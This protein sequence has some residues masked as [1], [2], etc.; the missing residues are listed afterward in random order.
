MSSQASELACRLAYNA[1]AVCRQYL[2]NGHR[3]GHYWIVGDVANTPGRSLYVR[4]SGPLSGKGARG[5]WT[6]AATGQR[7]DLLDLI[8]LS[9]GFDHLSKVIAEA[10]RFLGLPQPTP[11]RP[12]EPER[13]T[14]KAARRLLVMSRPLAGTLAETYLR[15]RGIAVTPD[16]WPLRFHPRCFCRTTDAPSSASHYEV[17]PALLAAVTS[18][19]GKVTGALRTFLDPSGR[20][21]GIASPRR[22]LGKLAGHGVRFGAAHDVMAVGEGLETILS[23]HTAVAMPVAAALSAGNLTFFEPPVTLRRLYVAQDND[24]AGQQAA[25]NLSLR[26][27]CLGIE[28][29]MLTP[30][31]KDFND[32]LRHLGVDGLRTML[33]HQLHP[34]DVS[35]FVTM[36]ALSPQ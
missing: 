21:A 30:A 7:G 3:Q 36:R 16:P 35:R 34:E 1:E 13:S 23:V 9:C 29:V 11:V 12:P 17:W 24:P 25:R 15:A 8:G 6:D 2:S 22:A 32:D 18:L 26:V 4:L 5:R 14:L 20:K 33:R 19:D 27:L 28:T 10:H 31:R